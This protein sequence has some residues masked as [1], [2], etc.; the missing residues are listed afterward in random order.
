MYLLIIIFI[1][2]I[3]TYF[4]Y[5]FYSKKYFKT[6][7]MYSLIKTKFKSNEMLKE[8]LDNRNK[9]NIDV[10]KSPNDKNGYDNS[11]KIIMLN[12]TNYDTDNVKSN[13]V[14]LHELAHCFQWEEKNFSVLVQKIFRWPLLILGTLVNFYLFV[15]IFFMFFFNVTFLYTNTILILSII[16]VLAVYLFFILYA[17]NDYFLEKNANKKVFEFM[18][19]YFTFSKEEEE[20]F[21]KVSKMNN[22]YNSL[23]CVLPLMMF[24]Q[25]IFMFVWIILT[26][27]F[28][29]I[30]VILPKRRRY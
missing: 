27:L 25:I 18:S 10:V 30:K 5:V 1:L 15:Y 7:E 9:K 2:T 16:S 29:L 8:I 13:F 3:V 26:F 21:N 28:G 14:G 22:F 12:S 20:K 23:K 6:L 4:F 24:F 17:I 19:E 11:R